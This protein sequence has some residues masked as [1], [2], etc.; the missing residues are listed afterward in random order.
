MSDAQF[1][2]MLI[3]AIVSL[4]GI[5]SIVAAI[6]VRPVINLNKNIEKL[7][8]TIDGMQAEEK[9]LNS[10]VHKHGLQIDEANLTLKEHDIIIKH[11]TEEIA[12]LKSKKA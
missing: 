4:L 3:G 9:S 6:I 5:A 8:V 10:R 2:G 1:M 12:E 7:N 11:H